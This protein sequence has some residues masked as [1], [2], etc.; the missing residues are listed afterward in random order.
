[1]K[2]ERRT[3][4]LPWKH[5]PAADGAEERGWM[6]EAEVEQVAT[7]KTEGGDKGR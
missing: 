1:M 2:D 4:G 7:E 6:T 3:A 5:E